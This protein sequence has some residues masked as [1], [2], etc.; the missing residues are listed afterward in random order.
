MGA[1]AW[2]GAAPHSPGGSLGQLSRPQAVH[3]GPAGPVLC[4]L[5]CWSGRLLGWLPS[6]V[7]AQGVLRLS[8]P[9]LVLLV[10]GRVLKLAA[11]DPGL[12]LGCR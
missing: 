6:P 10:Y 11:G 3:A 2:G 12:D 8:T 7:P 5:S 4:G 9:A 1:L